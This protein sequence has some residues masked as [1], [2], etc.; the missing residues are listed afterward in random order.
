MTHDELLEYLKGE[1]T[2]ANT[3]KEFAEEVG[4]SEQFLTD[5]LHGRREITGKLLKYFGRE[6]I[7]TYEVVS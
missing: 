4:I 7:V 3:Q 5:V 1:V 6:K 2:A